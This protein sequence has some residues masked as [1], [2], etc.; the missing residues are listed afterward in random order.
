MT[1][2]LVERSCSLLVHVE[3]PESAQSIRESL[4]GGDP[5]AKAAA[6]KNVISQLLNGE[7]LPT[8]FIT[9]VRYV[10]TRQRGGAR[11]AH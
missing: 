4:E 2:L 7:S 11:L 6:M 1:T 10:R 8:V 3:R 5:V 9:I